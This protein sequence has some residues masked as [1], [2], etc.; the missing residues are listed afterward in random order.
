MSCYCYSFI[1]PNAD[2]SCGE[3]KPKEEQILAER[4]KEKRYFK[5]RPEKILQPSS[6]V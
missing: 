5:I 1:S 3:K 4:N 2:S 6:E